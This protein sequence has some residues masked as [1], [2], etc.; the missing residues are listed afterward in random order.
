MDNTSVM[1][2]QESVKDF[3]RNK[4]F[5]SIGGIG[6]DFSYQIVATFYILFIQ[7]VVGLTTA[8]FAAVGIILV[9][10]RIFDALN[11]PVMGAIIEGSKLKWGK[12]KPWILLGAVLSAGVIVAMF[13]S[14][15]QGWNFVIFFGVMSFLWSIVFTINDVSYWSMLPSLSSDSSRRNTA[16]TLTVVFATVGSIAANLVVMMFA[17]GNG[18]QAYPIIAIGTAIGFV[19][20]QSLTSFGVKENKAMTSTAKPKVSLKDMA[21]T[22]IRNDQLLWMVVVMLLYNVGSGLLIALGYN[23]IYLYFGYNG[24]YGTILIGIYAVVTILSQAFYP[25]LAKKFSRRKLIIIGLSVAVTGYLGLALMGFFLPYII[26]MY[27]FGAM[28]FAGQGV[29]YMTMVLGV[30]NCIEYNEYKT[31]ERKEAIIFSLRSLMAKM[32]SAL[33]Q[34]IVI[35]VLAISGIVLLSNGVSTL[36]NQKNYFDYLDSV[37]LQQQYINIINNNAD[38]NTKEF[39]ELDQKFFDDN[40]ISINI[41]DEF[42]VAK[43]MESLREG[44]V[45]IANN[46]GTMLFAVKVSDIA[47]NQ[48]EAGK[49]YVLVLTSITMEDGTVLN[50]A[51]DTVFRDKA[52]NSE[53]NWLTISISIVPAV[54]VLGAAYV[55][56]RKY[57]IDEQY[58]QMMLTEIEKKKQSA[59]IDNNES[60][61]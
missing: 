31:G 47:D 36:E 60:G 13:N 57:K 46:D 44:Y 29:F 23:F 35:A 10:M 45:C 43:V 22:I 49:K 41:A 56:I 11:D 25:K 34:L 32:G 28:I 61:N 58:Y 59:A 7:F 9:V 39:S 38:N 50:G 42:T 5:F 30:T 3:N 51:V 2:G 14:G 1:H 54:L 37:Q 52:T 4:W 17:V 26:L 19:A 6:R 24:M 21:V 48:L 12:Y 8:Q 16:T 15:L 33:Q 27:I 40:G 18:A 53:R 20:F 55:S